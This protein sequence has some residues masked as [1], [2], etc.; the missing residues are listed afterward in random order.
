MPRKVDQVDQ[1]LA[2][3]RDALHQAELTIKDLEGQIEAL[4]KEYELEIRHLR[5]SLEDHKSSHK[6]SKEHSWAILLLLIG[7]IIALFK[8]FFLGLIHSYFNVSK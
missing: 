8:D 4:R 7:L 2:K 1:D 6:L 5:E 3:V